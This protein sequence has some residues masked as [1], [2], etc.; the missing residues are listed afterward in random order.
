MS[1]VETMPTVITNE[2][3]VNREQL[4]VPADL[5]VDPINCGDDRPADWDKYIH[6]FGGVLFVAYQQAIL[7]EAQRPGSAENL[8]ALTTEVTPELKARGVQGLGVHSDTQAESGS[9]FHAEQAD[10]AVGCG[11]AA[12]RAAISQ[13]I[14]EN[15]EAIVSEAAG[16]FPELFIDESA[17]TFGA[18]VT[19]AHGSLAARRSQSIGEGRKLVLSAKDAGAK[20]ML[21]DGTHVASEGIINTR[22]DTTFDTNSA[23]QTGLAAYN[24]DLWASNDLIEMLPYA[25]DRQRT[26]IASVIDIIGTMKALGVQHIAV[27]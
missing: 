3:V 5:Y 18:Q 16:L 11:Y 25:P 21:V 22:R 19:A 26:A 23:N 4:F 12:K 17:W 9:M 6:I 27:R 8:D 20:V 24:H 15:G 2:T 13:L 10:G 7:Q 1:G 14:A